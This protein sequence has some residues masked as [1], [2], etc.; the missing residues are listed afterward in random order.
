MSLRIFVRLALL[1]GVSL[2]AWPATAEA[3][4]DTMDGPVV[5]AGMKALESG[6]LAPAL[7][8]IDE[9]GEAELRAAFA[10]ARDVRRGS[11]KA[12]ALA[13]RWFIE[14]LVRLHRAG[15]GEPYTGIKPAGTPISPAVA[16]AD[17]AVESGALEPLLALL[18][19][20]MKRGVEERFE[21][22]R[23]GRVYAPADVAAGRAYV[24]AYVQLVQHVEA[25]HDAA[26]GAG[27]HER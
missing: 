21:R 23:A 27:G 22:A 11:P 16:A 5:K 20:A 2:G 4:C 18:T 26:T 3:H 24:S 10:D 9:A 14:T 25:L 6:A 7:T 19:T 15:E 1:I 13:D 12:R 17:S 8:W